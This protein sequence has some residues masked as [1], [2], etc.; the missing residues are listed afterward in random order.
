[1]KIHCYFYALL[2]C[3]IH[4]SVLAQ[5]D[6]QLVG[7][8]THAD[9]VNRLGS[10][11]SVEL[12][13]FDVQFYKNHRFE[14]NSEGMHAKGTWSLNN[15]VL[16]LN[17]AP[18]DDREGRIQKLYIEK[19]DHDSLITEVKDIEMTGGLMIVMKRSR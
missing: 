12:K 3:F 10:H 17:V 9:V 16:I 2:F 6:K 19:L 14:M 18:A 13:P 5:T 7:S 11:V 4:L 15:S 1:M 8:W